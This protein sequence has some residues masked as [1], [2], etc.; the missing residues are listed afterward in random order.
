MSSLAQA[1]NLFHVVDFDVFVASPASR[2]NIYTWCGTSTYTE[3][4][5]NTETAVSNIR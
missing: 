5:Y 3:S 4:G 1:Y 2:L